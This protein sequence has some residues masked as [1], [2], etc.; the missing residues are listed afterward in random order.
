MKF[1]GLDIWESFLEADF[2]CDDAILMLLT[3]WP[4]L[5]TVCMRI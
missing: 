1:H 5:V 2:M 3:M 4:A